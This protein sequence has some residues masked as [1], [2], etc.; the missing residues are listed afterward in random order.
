MTY[1]S[2]I[3]RYIIDFNVLFISTFRLL[4]LSDKLTGKKFIEGESL[5]RC[6]FD[7]LS[8]RV[9]V[10]VLLLVPPRHTKETGCGIR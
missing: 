8:L 4:K 3:E 9:P 6:G 10:I 5:C 7:S 2:H 1:V